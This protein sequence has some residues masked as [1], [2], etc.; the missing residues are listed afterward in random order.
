MSGICHKASWW[1]SWGPHGALLL[2]RLLL[3]PCPCSA[4]M[5]CWVFSALIFGS[6]GLRIGHRRWKVWVLGEAEGWTDR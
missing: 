3:I 2:S 1:W 4:L 6:S 5:T